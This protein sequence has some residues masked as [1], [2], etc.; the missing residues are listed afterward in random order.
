MLVFWG[1]LR[2]I[3]CNYILEPQVMNPEVKFDEKQPRSHS[4]NHIGDLQF[5]FRW[6]CWWKKISQTTTWDGAKTFVNNGINYQPHLVFPPDFRYQPYFSPST[7]NLGYTTLSGIKGD[8]K[9]IAVCCHQ[10][11]FAMISTIL[12]VWFGRKEFWSWL[13]CFFQHILALLFQRVIRSLQLRIS[14]EF[15]LELYEVF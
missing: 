8:A 1:V 12:W 4:H 11:V 15:N 2:T 7:G 10:A 9:S 3:Y 6:Y 14:I 5:L 13:S